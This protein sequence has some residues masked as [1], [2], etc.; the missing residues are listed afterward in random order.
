MIHDCQPVTRVKVRQGETRNCQSDIL[1][2]ALRHY[3]SFVIWS[4]LRP[5]I[6]D[7]RRLSRPQSRICLILVLQPPHSVIKTHRLVLCTPTRLGHL[8]MRAC[9]IVNSETCMLKRPLSPTPCFLS[10]STVQNNTVFCTPV[11]T[12]HRRLSAA[13]RRRLNSTCR[14]RVEPT[15]QS[16]ESRPTNKQTLTNKIRISIISIRNLNTNK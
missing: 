15:Q 1:Q 8:E 3:A 11:T 7:S 9:T 12:V 14:S 5:L 2:R 4:C 10:S 16:V 13:S 6:H